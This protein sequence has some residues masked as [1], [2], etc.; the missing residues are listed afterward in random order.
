[1]DL[2]N[3]KKKKQAKLDALRAREEERKR[4]EELQAKIKVRQ[5]L[6]RMKIQSTK[7]ET[8]KNNWIE[9]ARKASLINNEKTYKLAKQS[10]RM[11][12][13]KQRFLESMICNFEIALQMNEM[14]KVVN[15]FI[16][17]MNTISNQMKEI[18]S[19]ID[20]TKAQAAYDK[21]LANNEGQ[22]EALQAFLDEAENSIESFA[23]NEN[24]VAEDEI[25][26]LINTRAVDS[27]SEMDD[28]IEK[29]LGEIRSKMNG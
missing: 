25:D 22:Y 12:L 21:A 26:R 10:L 15:E 23:G 3:L 8:M 28:E 20:I 11:C 24:D 19:S 2:F 13:S 14:N 9:Q 7:M 29:K 16:S 5:T 1:M 18:T 17:G 4:E 6:S 27:E